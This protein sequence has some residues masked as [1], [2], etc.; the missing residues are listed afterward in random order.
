MRNLKKV[1]AL[2]AVFAMMVSTVAFAQ[3]FSDVDVEHDYYE[4]IEML[5]NLDILTGDDQDGD[6]TMDFRAEDKITRAEVATIISRIQG[7]NSA[8]QVA[9]DFADVPATHWA[10]GFVAQAAGQGIVNGY[11]D[12][13]FGP[14][15]NVLYEQ[16]IKML[17]VTLGYTPF[18]EANGGYPSGHL[19]AAQRFGIVDGVIGASVGA[20]ATRGQIAQLVYNA[21]DTPL[22]D[23]ATY[24]ANAEYVIYDDDPDTGDY[25]FT[26][27]LTRDLG[28]K[29]FTGYVTENEVT[30]YTAAQPIDTEED[31]E[32]KVTPDASK[33][34]SN[35]EVDEIDTWYPGES[36]I[37]ALIG[38]HVTGYAQEDGKNGEYV[39]IAAA[40]TTEND[41]IASFTIDAFVSADADS[42]N[43]LKNESD[44]K[45]TEAEV[46]LATAKVFLNGVAADYTEIFDMGGEATEPVRKNSAV[47]GTV[48]IVDNGT[49]EIVYVSIGVPALVDE[50]YENGDVVFKNIP[51]ILGEAVELSFDEDI[52]NQIVELS[53]DG[54]AIEWTELAADDVLS[55][56][57]NPDGK[58]YVA[59]VVAGG[60]VEGTISQVAKSATSK[61]GNKYTIDGKTYDVA[62]G[63]DG[64]GTL[65]AG[66]SG[67]FYIDGFGKIIAYDKNGTATASDSYAYFIK[68]TA[69]SDGWTKNVKVQL[70]DK[71][72]EIYTAYLADKI[73]IA[74]ANSDVKA[75]ASMSEADATVK[76][77][78]INHDAFAGLLANQVVTYAANS[79]GEIKE[80]TFAKVGE[81]EDTLS[82]YA[83]GTA[84]FDEED[85]EATIAGSKVAIDDSTIVFFIK[86]S[87]TISAIGDT[88]NFAN[89]AY[90]KVATGAAVNNIDGYAAAYDVNDDYASVLVV[91]NATGGMSSSAPIAVLESIGQASVDGDTTYAITY[92]MNGAQATSYI[93]EDCI[94]TSTA[95]GTDMTNGGYVGDLY[96]LALSADG[97]I[98]TEMTKYADAPAMS[99]N[100]ANA[101]T[102]WNFTDLGNGTSDEALVWGPIVERSASSDMIKIAQMSAVDPLADP[103]VYA[104][105]YDNV[106]K[107]KNV[108]KANVYVVDVFAK[109]EITV[110]TIADAYANTRLIEKDADG[111]VY[112]KVDI[113]K[114]GKQADGVTA[115][116]EVGAGIDALGMLDYAVAFTYD[117]D[118]VDVVIYKAYEFE[119]KLTK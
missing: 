27:L 40:E 100:K 18:A 84:T 116:V 51:E 74:N 5:S 3:S 38:K 58:Y 77:E 79:A 85:R 36:G 111:S 112:N 41:V 92:W 76:L 9:T 28:V 63:Y 99:D 59:E 104:F 105:D 75:A 53:K 14:E 65:K 114:D 22:M 68:A 62:E 2:V 81:Y 6:G 21:I 115:G 101:A 16:A 54:A 78:D 37:G 15:D 23:S 55:I 7:I 20:E 102:A 96:K 34:N 56:F 86:G 48:E 83:A 113:D 70:L 39:V 61:D 49:D 80:I 25:P 64:N 44:K 47:S 107:I 26:T 13:N 91:L 12:G 106:A 73:T 67:V 108:S 24:G 32:V 29:K 35:Y 1:I 119:Y 42:I 45:A 19:L 4:A 66:A 118:A 10:S 43:Y 57:W 87:S 109:N 82:Q 98:I 31:A 60:K 97:T 71:S 46:A 69:G 94:L 89:V 117:D 11:G 17:A 50:V 30:S 110:G 95:L 52:T 93:A 33:T 103:V 90:S 88:S 72:G 8:S